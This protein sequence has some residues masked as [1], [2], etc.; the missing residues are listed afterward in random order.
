MNTRTS[1]TLSALA[2]AGA[3][4]GCSSMPGFLGGTSN[5]LSFNNVSQAPLNVTYYLPAQMPAEWQGNPN[6]W[7]HDGTFVSDRTFQIDKGETTNYKV[8]G[9]R[10]GNG[11]LPVHIRVEPVSASW[12][13]TTSTYWLEILTH[14]PVS[15]VAT[16][17]VDDLTFNTGTGAIAVIPNMEIEGGRFNHRMATVPETDQP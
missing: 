6:E 16:G 17:P 5:T 7:D 10:L 14:P 9:S 1:T 8:A 12:D 13:D 3:M 2:L 4:T 11:H 15:I